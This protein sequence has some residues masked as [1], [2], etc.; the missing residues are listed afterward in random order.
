M[1]RS[2]TLS[3]A[4]YSC[5]TF[6]LCLSLTGCWES[7]PTQEEIDK[8]NIQAAN[9]RAAQEAQKQKQ[10]E[11][12]AAESDGD[13]LVATADPRVFKATKVLPKPESSANSVKPEY[14]ALGYEHTY[15]GA[16]AVAAYV[17]SLIEY[18][19]SS[20]DTAEL[21]NVCPNTTSFC[22][23]LLD[24]IAENERD[25][26]W[27]ADL[28]SE[29]QKLIEWGVP[30]DTKYGEYSFHY[31][32]DLPPYKYFERNKMKLTVSTPKRLDMYFNVSYIGG[33]WIV[34]VGTKDVINK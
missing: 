31:Q 14:P 34:V 20:G 26:N 18:S 24:S 16:E 6:T 15:E 27:H 5:L 30:D 19:F 28:S 22:K 1:R 7:G 2:T 17:E 3:T 21:K 33:R 23:S 12:E 29:N 25:G 8:A 11:K 32:A 13:G 9:E 4:L 10:L